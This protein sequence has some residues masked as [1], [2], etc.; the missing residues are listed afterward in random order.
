MSMF[1]VPKELLAM[2]PEAYTPQ[3]VSINP[4]HR[5]R[6]ELYDMERYKVAVA[7]RFRKRIDGKKFES[8]VVEEFEKHEWKIQNNYHKFLDYKEETL[9][10][11]MALDTAFLLEFLKFYVK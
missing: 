3:L 4:Y 7:Q 2:K 10:W 6:F 8:V 9:A 1:N 11:I 5:L